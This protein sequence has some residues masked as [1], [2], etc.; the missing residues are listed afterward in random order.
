MRGRDAIG[1]GDAGSRGRIDIACRAGGGKADLCKVHAIGAALND[2]A[3]G[4][5]RTFLPGEVHGRRADDRCGKRGR[6]RRRRRCTDGDQLQPVEIGDGDPLLPLTSITSRSMCEPGGKTELLTVTVCQCLPAAGSGSGD[7]AGDVLAI[8]VEVELS[9]GGLGVG[10]AEGDA[11]CA[12]LGKI[13]GIIEPLAGS[14]PA[15]VIAAAGVGGRLR[16]RRSRRCD[17]GRRSWMWRRWSSRRR[18]RRC[19][20]PRPE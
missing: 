9:A 18:C 2:K 13:D 17:I 20:S 7:G 6:R 19:R 11:V 5:R 1:V 3:G 4:V 14:G 10:D 12:A 8:D 16:C 15:D